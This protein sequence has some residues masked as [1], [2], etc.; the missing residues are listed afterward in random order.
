MMKTVITLVAFI[1]IFS[2]PAALASRSFYSPDEC[3][4]VFYPKPLSV[5][6]VVSYKYTDRMCPMEGVLFTMQSNANIC[7][8]PS[9]EWVKNILKAKQ[10][11]KAKNG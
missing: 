11:V 4:F 5:K 7:G 10:K 8:D 9:V 3:C 2:S 1:L 6:K